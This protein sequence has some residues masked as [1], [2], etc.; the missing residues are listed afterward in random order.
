[1]DWKFFFFFSNILWILIGSF[2][3]LLRY[4]GLGTQ[5]TQQRTFEQQHR[6]I[7]RYNNNSN[8]NNNKNVENTRSRS[9]YKK[10]TGV[11]NELPINEIKLPKII[12]NVYLIEVVLLPKDNLVAF[13]SLA[14]LYF[15]SK[16]EESLVKS[17]DSIKNKVGGWHHLLP[18]SVSW[19]NIT[20]TINMSNKIDAKCHFLPTGLFVKKKTTGYNFL[21]D[22]IA[23][24]YILKY[25]YEIRFYN[26][27]ITAL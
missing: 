19:P 9:H 18:P 22:R 16:N 5:L 23:G 20:I 14:P 15:F 2:Y 11:Y 8:N 4:G 21:S 10:Y 6:S 3:F 7:T 27:A 24:N 25:L 12:D 26:G 17:T 13:F 1:M